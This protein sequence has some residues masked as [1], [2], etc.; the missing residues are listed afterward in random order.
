LGEIT[1]DNFDELIQSHRNLELAPDI[2]LYEHVLSANYSAYCFGKQ[3]KLES[4]ERSN[5]LLNRWIS[6]Y[7]LHA[8]DAV[9]SGSSKID[10]SS[11]SYSQHDAMYPEQRLFH[12]VMRQ[13][14]DLWTKE[15]SQR[16]EEWLRR[17]ESLQ[18]AGHTHCSPDLHAYNLVLLSYCNLCKHSGN[19][20]PQAGGLKGDRGGFQSKY[21]DESTRRYILNGVE[22]IMLELIDSKDIEINVFSLDLALN[23]FAKAG[24]NEVDMCQR[25]DRLLSKVLDEKSFAELIGGAPSVDAN[26]WPTDSNSILENSLTSKVEPDLDTYHW[27]VDIYSSSGNLFYIQ[28]ATKLLKKMVQLRT[29]IDSD[30]D[31]DGDVHAPST[32]TFNNALRAMQCKVDELER[33]SRWDDESDLPI[34]SEQTRG[35]L[36]EFSPIDIARSLTPLIDLMIQFETSLPTRVTFLFMLQIWARTQS[37]EAGDQAEDLLSRMEVLHTYHQ[38]KPFSNAYKLVLQSWLTSAKAG[39]P[40][41]VQRAHRRVHPALL[42][43]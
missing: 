32:G 8:R 16:V 37:Q 19:T 6:L 11:L 23:A 15:G 3:A 27:L 9:A 4:T 1:A 26:G 28:R 21:I 43:C 29:E 39:R 40:G 18:Q 14:T 20:K 41:A 25:T 12:L 42:C 31:N 5:R 22:N 24:R 2:S 35:E 33:L 38:I 7:C 10:S 13:N 36:K 34:L 17:M 30:N